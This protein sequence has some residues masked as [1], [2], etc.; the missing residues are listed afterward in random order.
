[1]W[2]VTRVLLVECTCALFSPTSATF[3]I[4]N[5]WI[6]N[7]RLFHVFSLKKMIFL[8]TSLCVYLCVSLCLCESVYLYYCRCVTMCDLM[9]MLV[10]NIY[11]KTLS[12]ALNS[13]LDIRKYSNRNNG[14]SWLKFL[15]KL[16]S[17]ALEIYIFQ[18]VSL[19]QFPLI[20][21]YTV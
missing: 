5:T 10:L 11:L 18:I 19:W 17:N 2:K 21:N 9:N 1:M 12:S 13:L 16:S 20:Q 4:L 15:W 6:S 8:F 14:I 3:H 7:V